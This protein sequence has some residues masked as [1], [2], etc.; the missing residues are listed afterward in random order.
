MR[1][2]RLV[3]LMMTPFSVEVSSLGSPAIFQPWITTG[4]PRNSLIVTLLEHSRPTSTSRD[5]HPFY[6]EVRY[7]AVK[8]P[9]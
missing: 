8:G 7:S 2:Q 5:A 6:I 9:E 4:T 3:L 1:G